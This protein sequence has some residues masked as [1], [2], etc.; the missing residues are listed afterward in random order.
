MS[1]Q[2]WSS[3]SVKG[4]PHWRGVS[5]YIFSGLNLF[6]SVWLLN[7]CFLLW[8][9]SNSERKLN[10]LV[11]KIHIHP[12]STWTLPTSCSHHAFH[13]QCRHTKGLSK[14]W[15]LLPK[16]QEGRWST[17]EPRRPAHLSFVRK[18][19]SQLGCYSHWQC[20]SWP[21][22]AVLHES[23]Y[24]DSWLDLVLESPVANHQCSW[25]Q[26][27][28]QT[29]VTKL[30]IVRFSVDTPPTSQQSHGQFLGTKCSAWANTTFW[31]RI[32]FFLKKW[33]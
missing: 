2:L 11:L 23:F 28:F 21:D 4:G 8:K 22:G 26:I 13:C 19:T 18:T 12:H 24:R 17:A 30:M 5:V 16:A 15:H 31:N 7:T 1:S 3:L 27:I 9:W 29:L 32:F 14:N 25:N 10:D 20:G 33:I 6:T